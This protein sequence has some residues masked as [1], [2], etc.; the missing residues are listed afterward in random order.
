MSW[1]KVSD[2][3][4]Q[5][6]SGMSIDVW[7]FDT[8]GEVRID[9]FTTEN[10]DEGEF[11]MN[12]AAHEHFE[13]VAPASGYDEEHDVHYFPPSKITHWMEIEYPEAPK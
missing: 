1:T 10:S 13:A 6:D 2:G 9:Q 4:P 12:A 3:L 5:L 11:V 8:G 7:T